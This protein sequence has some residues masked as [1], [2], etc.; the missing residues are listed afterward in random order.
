MDSPWGMVDSLM[1]ELGALRNDARMLD[2]RAVAADVTAEVDRYIG[3]AA[4]AIDEAISA[5]ENETRLLAVCEA[6]VVARA[7]IE[8]LVS[9]TRKTQDLVAHSHDLIAHGQDLRRQ[10]ARL[11]YESLRRRSGQDA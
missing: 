9:T 2:S 5:P 10:N 7:R 4:Q 11:L 1:R 6:I 3:E 8:A